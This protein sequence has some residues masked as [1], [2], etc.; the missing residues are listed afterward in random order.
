MESRPTMTSKESE[1]VGWDGEMLTKWPSDIVRQ[2]AA[3]TGDRLQMITWI[4]YLEVP[5]TKEERYAFDEITEELI[6]TCPGSKPKILELETVKHKAPEG[7]K[8]L[9]DILD[10]FS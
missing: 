5:E 10:I 4:R 1:A 9:D 7:M 8:L 2:I 6:A 3:K